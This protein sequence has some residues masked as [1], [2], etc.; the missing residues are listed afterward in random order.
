MSIVSK[1]PERFIP[2]VKALVHE[3]VIGNFEGLAADGLAGRL[4]AEELERAVRDYPQTIVDLP[5]EAFQ[6]AD[7]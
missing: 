6:F 1:V 2:A 3:L 5:D 4:T 7:A